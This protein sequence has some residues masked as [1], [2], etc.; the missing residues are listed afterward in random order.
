MSETMKFPNVPFDSLIN[1]EVSGLYLKRCQ[2]ALISFSERLGVENI[3]AIFEKMKE[4]KEPETV[5]ESIIYVL[6][7]LI[8]TIEKAADKQGKVQYTEMTSE[9]VA[10]VF[11]NL[12]D[13][14][15]S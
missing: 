10:E 6:L 14:I 7:P 4:K 8:D 11:K 3:Q 13:S 15:G 1:I 5:D 2:T 9:Q 12:Q